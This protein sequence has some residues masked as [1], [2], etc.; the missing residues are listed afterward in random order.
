MKTRRMF[1]V[2]GLHV[3][4]AIGRGRSARWCVLIS[5]LLLFFMATPSNSSSAAANKVQHDLQE[6]CGKRAREQFQKDFGDGRQIT[7]YGEID[8][9]FQSNY[10]EILN[11]CFMSYTTVYA[12]TKP[13]SGVHASLFDANTNKQVGLFIQYGDDVQVCYVA[14]DTCGSITEWNSL[15]KTYMSGVE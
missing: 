15:I 5:A 13:P 10:N 12:N 1:S 11:E 14:S 6:R 4:R 7:K 8:T 2:C 3:R 9:T